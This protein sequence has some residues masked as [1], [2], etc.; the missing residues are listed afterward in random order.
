MAPRVRLKRGVAAI[1]L[2]A[3]VVAG[4]SAPAAASIS[5]GYMIEVDGPAQPRIGDTLTLTPVIQGDFD[6][7]T[8]H[9]CFMAIEGFGSSPNWVRMQVSSNTCDPWTFV[10]PDAAAGSFWIHGQVVFADPEGNPL[11]AAIVNGPT[12]DVAAGDAQP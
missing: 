4:G 1:V 11:E 6:P 12:I 5:F 10:I 9:R 7:S 3:A 2:G 8:L